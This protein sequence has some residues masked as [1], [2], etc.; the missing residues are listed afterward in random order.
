MPSGAH[1]RLMR[2]GLSAGHVKARLAQRAAPGGRARW[3]NRPNVDF[4]GYWQ[5]GG[6]GLQFGCRGA[7]HR[8]LNPIAS[9]SRPRKRHRMRWS[10]S[11]PR[12]LKRRTIG[13]AGP[14]T[15]R[16]W[17]K[18]QVSSPAY[19]SPSQGVFAYPSRELSRLQTAGRKLWHG[20][21][22]DYWLAQLGL[23]S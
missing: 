21:R 2:R 1:W 13:L 16:I 6:S 15:W 18:R 7:L 17:A 22:Q 10:S 9:S 14:G 23:A 3:R 4:R 5:R 11:L 12:R 20:F 19:S 8:S